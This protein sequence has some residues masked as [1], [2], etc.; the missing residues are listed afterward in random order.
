MSSSTSSS[1]RSRRLHRATSLA[2]SGLLASAREEIARARAEAKTDALSELVAG[3][4]LFVARDYDGSLQALENAAT[5]GAGWQASW[6]RYERAQRIGWEPEAIKSLETA[7]AE[8]P[9]DPRLRAALFLI[10]VK[11]QNWETAIPHGLALCAALPTRPGPPIELASVYAHLGRSK[12]AIEQIKRAT[13]TTRSV[14]VNLEA[15]RLL[16]QLGELEASR[17]SFEEA[18]ALDPSN[19]AAKIGLA[20]FALWS[21]QAER[22]EAYAKQAL[23]EDE[24]GGAERLLGILAWLRGRRDEAAA[25]LERA[26]LLNPRDYEAHAWLAAIA[27]AEK[28]YE[29]AHE[30]LSRTIHAAPGVV[31][32]ADLLRLRLV[33]EENAKDPKKAK[34]PH[35]HLV[36]HLRPCL[37]LLCP[38]DRAVIEDQDSPAWMDMLDRALARM[39]GNRSVTPTFLE[40]GLLRPL[41]NVSDPR[42]E[43]RRVLERIRVTP[44]EQLLAEFDELCRKFPKSSLPLAHKGELLI[45]LGRL[46]EGRAALEQAIKMVVG[47]R[48][49]YIG[50]STLEI[51]AGDYEEALSVSAFGVQVMQ[52]TEGPAVRVHR[53][54]ALRRLGRLAEAEP[55]LEKAVQ[56]HPK[57]VSGWMNLS[58]LRL[59]QGDFE[60]GAE[61]AAEVFSLAPSLMTD[62]A[63]D[64]GVTLFGDR[65]E[66]PDA[67][68]L[69]RVMEKAL[70]L[71][72]GNRS[73][74]CIT[75][76]NSN[77][78]LRFGR[79][80]GGEAAPLHA[81]D[82]EDMD[83]AKALLTRGLTRTGVAAKP[84][85]SGLGR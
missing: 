17:A 30:E 28:N 51:L 12:E 60:R 14:P 24:S 69:T 59:A 73:S 77:G 75:Y 33:W 9:E 67:G 71:S 46:E 52:N 47:T 54:E 2:A 80:G 76:V 32:A 22:A 65:G 1:A 45:W 10:H 49:A 72:W 35:P 61:A 74:T 7:V 66:M 62:A 58:L 44:P 82:I 8:A 31:F 63:R 78:K 27:L 19:V 40:N 39:H 81:R 18:L 57:R 34:E 5:L 68:S 21:G 3:L 41:N 53:G 15:A 36:D 26:L 85:G 38:E 20:E 79:H 48:W 43:S 42:A 25:R 23:D 13:S 84:K 56:N 11:R 70:A 4:V 50:L 64:V 55:D 29:R 37:L 83:L 16:R 6:L